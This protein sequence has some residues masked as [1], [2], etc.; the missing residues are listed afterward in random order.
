MFRGAGTMEFMHNLFN[1]I[2]RA[3]VHMDLSDCTVLAVCVLAVGF[4]CLRGFGSRTN[5]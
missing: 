2:S 1:K 3:A 4:V 5:W